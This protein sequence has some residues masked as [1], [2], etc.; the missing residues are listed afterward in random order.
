MHRLR[1]FPAAIVAS[2]ILASTMPALSLQSLTRDEK[3]IILD[4]CL[5]AGGSLKVCCAA[6]G[7][8]YKSDGKGGGSCTTSADLVRV[9]HG[10]GGT[11]TPKQPS[12]SP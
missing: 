11:G 5:T 2:T 7:G 9:P 1:L 6:A 12:L 3:G 10:T 4:R 8:S